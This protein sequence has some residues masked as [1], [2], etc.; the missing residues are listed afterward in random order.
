MVGAPIRILGWDE[1]VDGWAVDRQGDPT[2]TSVQDLGDALHASSSRGDVA[3]IVSDEVYQEMVDRRAA[4]RPLPARVRIEP[5]PLRP[6]TVTGVRLRRP[7]LPGRNRTD[8]RL[9]V[10]RVFGALMGLAVGLTFLVLREGQAA[11]IFLIG[12]PVVLAFDVLMTRRARVWSTPGSDLPLTGRILRPPNAAD[13]PHAA[14]E[15]VTL[16]ATSSFTGGGLVSG[17]N[18]TYPFVVLTVSPDRL[19]VKVLASAN[20][21][22]VT[23]GPEEVTT[24]FPFIGRAPRLVK[25]LAIEAHTEPHTYF[26]TTRPEQV[27]TLLARAGYPVD[28]AE[29]LI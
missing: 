5:A 27:L 29:R 26:W 4:W 28:W 9:A 2:L 17:I 6:S 25:G 11:A 10:R 16:I 23:L 8:R 13:I 22:T 15:G 1:A 7:W 12:T 19:T 18:A 3:I 20:V 14:S 21:F 24:I